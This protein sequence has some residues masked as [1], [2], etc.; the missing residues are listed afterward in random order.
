MGVEPVI[1][2]HEHLDVIVPVHRLQLRIGDRI[3][4]DD[5]VDRGGLEKGAGCPP[6]VVANLPHPHVNAALAAF[7]DLGRA[8]DR[9]DPSSRSQRTEVQ[10]ATC[11]ATGCLPQQQHRAKQLMK[12]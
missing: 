11:L 9:L 6:V 1:P 3:G 2:V 10:A 8:A 4:R 5:V 7:L 12:R